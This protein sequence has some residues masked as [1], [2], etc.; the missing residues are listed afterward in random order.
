MLLGQN[1]NS[2]GK[3]LDNPITFAELINAVANVEGLERVRF[4]TPHPKDFSDELIDVIAANKKICRHIH[5]PLQS[6]SSRILKAM[7]RRYT[8][9]GYLALVDKIRTKLPDVA[10]TTDIIVGFPGETEEDFN[11]TIDVV[12][13][14]EFD[15]AFTFIY[16]KRI[17]TPAAVMDNQIPEEITKERFSRLLAVVNE[18]AT[19]RCGLDRGKTLPVLV[20]DV[21]EQ[22]PELLTG[23]LSNNTLVHFA[24]GKELIGQIVNV[25][26]N[27]SK[28]FYYLGEKE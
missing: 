3:N 26:L 14:A 4:M 24:G 25:K 12:R 17:G 13:K 9:E 23:R 10:L 18:C 20:E 1:V 21:N 16:S 19:K 6:G 11:D 2:Y 5:L 22:N 28:G 15:S 27:E 8:K 7:N